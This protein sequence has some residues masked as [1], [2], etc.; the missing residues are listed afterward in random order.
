MKNPTVSII[1]PNFNGE[2]F[3]PTCLDTVLSSAYSDFEVILIDDC[4]KDN[5]VRIINNYK[6]KSKKIILLKNKSNLGAAASRNK[7]IAKVKGEIVIFLDNDTEVTRNWIENLIGPFNKDSKI[8][9]VQALILDF[10]QRDLI[11]MSGGK[12]IPHTGWLAPFYQWRKY[13]QVK[14]SLNQ[15]EIVGISAALAVRKEVLGKV[16]GFDEK[17]GIYTEDLDF[18]WRIWLAGYKIVLAPKSI[19]YHWSKS[20]EKRTEMN[21]TY[22][23]IYFNLAKNSFR[24]IIK[25]YSLL[26]SFRFLIA[27]LFVNFTRGILVLYKRKQFAALLG[28][29]DAV[30]WNFINIADTLNERRNT[31]KVRRIDDAEL[32][33]HIGLESSL[34][35]IYNKYF[36]QT[37]LI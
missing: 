3:L 7:A 25:N 4:S 18:C 2:K 37:K 15:M 14:S 11:Q 24:S 36:R 9:A 32:L 31:Q 23:K 26:N 8:G 28:T 6:S 16:R 29:I 35:D 20:V 27:S 30:L 10:N 13:S 33:K 1:I 19:I 12:L 22:Q 21:A 34:L 17:E 5:S